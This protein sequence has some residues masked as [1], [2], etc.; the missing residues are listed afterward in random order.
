VTPADR[1][2]SFTENPVLELPVRR[3]AQFEK[4]LLITQKKPP[5][6]IAEAVRLAAS[7]IAIIDLSAKVVTL[8]F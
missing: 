7:I 5:I 4:N 3:Q 8:C 6:I 2:P 1:S